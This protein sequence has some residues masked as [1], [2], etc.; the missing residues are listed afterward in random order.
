MKIIN[1]SVS[2]MTLTDEVRIS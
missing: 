2:R 1:I